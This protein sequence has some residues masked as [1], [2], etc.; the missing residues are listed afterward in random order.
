MISTHT[1]SYAPTN[2]LSSAACATVL[3]RMCNP[4]PTL[5]QLKSATHKY[6]STPPPVRATCPNGSATHL[7]WESA[8]NGTRQHPNL[9]NRRCIARFVPTS[10]GK[11]EPVGFSGRIVGTG[12]GKSTTNSANSTIFPQMDRRRASSGCRSAPLAAAGRAHLCNCADPHQCQHPEVYHYR[13]SAL[14]A[15]TLELL[16][17]TV[18]RRG[19]VFVAET[20]ITALHLPFLLQR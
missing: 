5:P 7:N 17:V 4:P 15:D 8:K 14:M 20:A 6:Q 9:T 18:I 2:T 1:L 13:R 12:T 3:H 16:I 10:A 19:P 11:A